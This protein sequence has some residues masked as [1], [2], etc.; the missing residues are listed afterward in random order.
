MGVRAVPFGRMPLSIMRGSTH[1]RFASLPSS[2]WPLY[3]VGGLYGDVIRRVVGAG[4]KP[5][6]QGL[7]GLDDS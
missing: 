4:A 2:N 7:D 6:D 3:L 1:S 5:H